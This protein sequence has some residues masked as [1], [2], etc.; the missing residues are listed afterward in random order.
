MEYGS[1]SPGVQNGKVTET[2]LVIP[3]IPE[4]KYKSL[5]QL[6][7]LTPS[8]LDDN[9][10][11][12]KLKIGLEYPAGSTGCN[13]MIFTIW[14]PGD[15]AA[16]N[17]QINDVS[18]YSTDGPFYG[19]RADASD[20]GLSNVSD[21]TMGGS[22]ITNTTLFPQI[23]ECTYFPNSYKQV[24][25]SSAYCAADSGTYRTFAYFNRLKINNGLNLG[26]YSGDE[27]CPQEFIFKSLE[28]YIS[29]NSLDVFGN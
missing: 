13:P 24:P 10:I 20:R 15:D 9:D 25:W 16:M 5:F 28:I 8:V 21:D 14:C 1:P 23:Y 6:Q 2:S 26:I 22:P 18:K 29:I 7:L 17:I 11:V 27:V 4:Q 19:I 3:T 12:V